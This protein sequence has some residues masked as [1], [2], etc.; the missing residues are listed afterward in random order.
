MSQ[1]RASALRMVSLYAHTACI[2][3]CQFSGS[4]SSNH[5]D[6]SSK[7][8]QSI[9]LPVRLSHQNTCKTSYQNVF[10]NISHP[11]AC[12]I[13]HQSACKTSLQN[14]S[15]K[16]SDNRKTSSQWLITSIYCHELFNYASW[17]TS[18]KSYNQCWAKQIFKYGITAL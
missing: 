18:R 15:F 5:G 8:L 17:L 6:L 10:K 1:I 13:S 11:N 9:M 14:A 2:N 3:W 4:T 12:K 16:D 7:C